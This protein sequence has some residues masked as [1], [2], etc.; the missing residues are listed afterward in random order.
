VTGELANELLWDEGNQAHATRHGV[1]RAEIDAMYTMG[2]W[3]VRND[4][5]GRTG[6]YR[7]TGPTPAGRLITVAVD[8]SLRQSA[9]RPI[10]AWDATRSEQRDWHDELN[11]ESR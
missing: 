1:S 3:I 4:P 10:S 8:W 9:Y 2:E 7:L 5:Q 6:Q 11:T